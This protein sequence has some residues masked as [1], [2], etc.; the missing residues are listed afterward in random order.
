[1]PPMQTA[2]E[3]P[4]ALHNSILLKSSNRAAALLKRFLHEF[5]SARLLQCCRKDIALRFARNHKHSIQIP[6]NDVARPDPNVPDLD[7]NPKIHDFVTRSGILPVAS[8]REGRKVE[9]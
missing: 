7:R 6:E 8:P 9:F 2:K 1:M 4:G 5:F 3:D